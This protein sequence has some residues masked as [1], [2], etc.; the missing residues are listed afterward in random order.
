MALSETPETPETFETPETP[1]TP[2]LR[3]RRA[4]EGYR[5]M[6]GLAI[7]TGC[8]ALVGWGWAIVLALV[9]VS[10]P[11]PG[12]LHGN[13]CG[14]PALFD[15]SAYAASLGAD[16]DFDTYW[17]GLCADK[18]SVHIRESVGLSVVTAPIS[19]L[20]IWSA[21]TVPRRRSTMRS[22]ALKPTAA[23]A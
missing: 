9:P 1:E 4:A 23:A 14:T 11:I 13:A 22:T 6:L 3:A 20:W 10:V 18:V 17:A 7:A 5:W 21:C 16:K 15:E 12:H 2:E 8:L 19:A